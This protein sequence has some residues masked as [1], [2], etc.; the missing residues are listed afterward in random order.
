LATPSSEPSEPLSLQEVQHFL[1]LLDDVNQIQ[2]Q[3]MEEAGV[4]RARVQELEARNPLG[5]RTPLPAE[6]EGGRA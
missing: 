2:Q 5:S 1:R 6:Q 4:L 3:L